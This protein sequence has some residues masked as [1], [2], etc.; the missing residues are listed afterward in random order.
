MSEIDEL[1]RKAEQFSRLSKLV[2]NDPMR[3]R[4]SDLAAE[5]EHEME[6]LR[7]AH[8]AAT[9]MRAPIRGRS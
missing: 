5:F 9:P 8:H 3:R 7:N 6:L 1:R 4:L 2:L